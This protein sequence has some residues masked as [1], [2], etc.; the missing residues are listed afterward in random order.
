MFYAF[1]KQFTF[2]TGNNGNSIC[3]ERKMEIYF[4]INCGTIA[5]DFNH[6]VSM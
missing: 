6:P 2:G 5:L 1:W 3:G 4:T